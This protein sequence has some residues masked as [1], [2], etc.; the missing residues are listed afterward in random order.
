MVGPEEPVFSVI[1]QTHLALNKALPVEPQGIDTA[2]LCFKSGFAIAYQ[3]SLI[4]MA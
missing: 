4:D 3:S 2:P 1:S